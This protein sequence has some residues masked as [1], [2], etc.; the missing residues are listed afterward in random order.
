MKTILYLSFYFEPDLCAGS[1]RNSNLVKELARQ[2]QGQAEVVLISTMPNRYSTF[3]IEAKKNEKIGNL[4]IHRV[5]LPAHRNGMFDQIKSFFFYFLAVRKIS[6]TE[7]YDLVVASSGRLFTAYLG[8]LISK[9]HKAPL[10]LDIRDVFVDTLK[11]VLKNPILRAGVIFVTKHV[12]TI[13]F[14]NAQHINLISCGFNNYFKRYVNP[15]YSNFTNGIDETF[16]NVTANPDLKASQF[17]ITYAGNIGE[18]QGLHIIIPQAA[19]LL[20][21]KYFFQIIGDGGAKQKLINSIDN[22]GVNNVKIIDPV[23]RSDLMEVY[24]KSHFL[25]MHLNDFDAFKKV[26][27]SKVFELGSFPQPLIAGVG[28]Y[29]NSFVKDNLSNYILF[30]PGDV[31]SFVHQVKGYKYC[32]AERTDF[33]NNFMRSKINKDLACSMSTYL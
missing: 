33:K 10:Y 16:L 21:D 23:K 20:G 25:F 31:E 24:A 8:Y 7:S 30:N 26:L 3:K 5:D 29:A 27:P 11:D 4:K 22:E 13:T 6:K 19:K 1:F 9:K 17:V 15:R 14:S 32:L 28:G 12:E 2:V 18:G